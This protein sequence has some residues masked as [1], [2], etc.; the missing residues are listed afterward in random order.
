M[1]YQP[2]Y[3][4]IEQ[5]AMEMTS[6]EFMNFIEGRKDLYDSFYEKVISG[7]KKNER[8]LFRYI[9]E[10]RDKNIEI[11]SSPYMLK[12]M[13][14]VEEDSRIIFKVTG[15]DEDEATTKVNELKKFIKQNAKNTKAFKESGALPDFSNL[16]PFRVILLFIM[17]YYLDSKQPKKLK[18]VC[19]Y[20]AY[21]MYYS[22]FYNFFR[23]P[24]RKE[25]MIY[26][27]NN[28]SNKFKI[29]QFQ[30]VDQLLE[31]A[32]ENITTAYPTKFNEMTDY[33]IIYLISQAKTRIRGYIYNIKN[34]YLKNDLAKNAIFQS[35]D[36]VGDEN[37]IIERRSSSGDV[38]KLAQMYTTD[39]FQRNINQQYV[40]IAAKS[41]NVPK[42]ELL[43]A[44]TI[45]RD[46][47]KNIN[48]VHLFYSSLFYLYLNDDN[49]NSLTS[50]NTS[51]FLASM[52]AVYKRGNSID[53]NIII[54]KKLMDEWLQAGSE[55]YRATNR[56][57]TMNNFRKAIYTYFVFSVA[58]RK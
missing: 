40:M 1:D 13:L 3:M 56:L 22:V 36:I 34:E 45:L 42:N 20:M 44:L 47:D 4:L 39:F 2:N 49:G 17:K 43:N 41:C 7:L 12:Y 58:L 26:T 54:V 28:M 52:E 38:D 37:D 53:K 10:Y 50:V 48:D 31:Y 29:K 35:S 25:T 23:T 18:E 24:P 32:V 9:A 33:D 15:I 5:I 27:M 16:V 11:L 57:A 14:F 30:S 21:S 51:K 6:A 55:A 19:A 46:D 8:Q